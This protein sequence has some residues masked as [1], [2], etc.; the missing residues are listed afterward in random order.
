[1]KDRRQ[2]NNPNDSIEI[3]KANVKEDSHINGS[4]TLHFSLTDPYRNGRIC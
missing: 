4:Y 2:L 3:F 1:M